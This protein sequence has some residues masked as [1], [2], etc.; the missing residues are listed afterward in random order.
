MLVPFLSDLLFYRNNFTDLPA[1][2]FV[3]LS[4]F[5]LLHKSTSASSS[6]SH[7]VS[8]L[9]CVVGPYTMLG[10]PLFYSSPSALLA[11][12]ITQHHYTSS[13]VSVLHSIYSSSHFLFTFFNSSPDTICHLC[14]LL[15]TYVGCVLGRLGL[16]PFPSCACLHD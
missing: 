6:H 10:L 4:V 3:I 12:S 1:C 13:N 15:R 5:V 11:C 8:F 7:P 14:F 16:I 2:S 9:V